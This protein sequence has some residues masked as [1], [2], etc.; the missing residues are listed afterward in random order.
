MN[1][2]AQA[3]A[4]IL[5]KAKVISVITGAGISTPSG[6]P[7]I[8]SSTG[9]MNNPDLLRKYGHDYETIVSHG[10]FMRHP[11]QF[12]R[13]YKD[14][15][16]H[17]EA[18]PNAAHVF[19]AELERKK[20]VTVITQ[21]IDGLHG[22]AG[23]KNVIEFHGNIQRNHCLKCG[24]FYTLDDVMKQEGVPRCP[25]CGGIIKP[26]VVLFEEPIDYDAIERSVSAILRSDLLL[27]IGSSLVVYPAAGLP[28]YYRGKELVII[29]K[30][31]TPL[32]YRASLIVREDV[33]AFVK[34]IDL[35]Q[36]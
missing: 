17:A 13:Y 7:D 24:A 10:F 22:L 34:K 11:E 4:D 2:K 23:S 14:Q 21:N 20:D 18:K 9:A 36:I 32:D 25:K 12:Y 8:R 19:L 15:M 5:R 1:D 26:D 27:I 33:S 16:V 31:P 28:N 30:D 3:F 6:I 29:N 35:S